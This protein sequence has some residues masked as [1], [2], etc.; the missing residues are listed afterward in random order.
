MSPKKPPKSRH[1][2]GVVE[3]REPVSLYEAKTHLS[4][5]VDLAAD[6]ADIII[7]KSGK[8]MARLG[9]LTQGRPERRPGRGRG[10]WTVSRD[11]D[12]PLP[13]D[14]QALFEPDR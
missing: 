5:L 9:P 14:V 1:G 7:M 6:G 8:P 10:Q 13:P 12:A 2:P 11:F 4:E 3:V